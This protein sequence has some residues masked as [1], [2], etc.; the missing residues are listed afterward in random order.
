[1]HSQKTI[2]S[3]LNEKTGDTYSLY[4]L[5]ERDYLVVETNGQI[6]NHHIYSTSDSYSKSLK[7]SNWVIEKINKEQMCSLKKL[8]KTHD[9]IVLNITFIKS[10]IVFVE[11]L[12]DFKKFEIEY[13]YEFHE[14]TIVGGKKASSVP[15]NYLIQ[16]AEKAIKN[17]TRYYYC[18]R[19]DEKFVNWNFYGS[20]YEE[21]ALCPNK[22]G[23]HELLDISDRM[24]NACS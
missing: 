20:G 1:M 9:P 13:D 12:Y 5:D 10:G 3:V 18:K 19:C 23:N 8:I 17:K 24:L 21:I 6:T 2:L 7:S 15:L 16:L 22:C 14:Y 4:L 11:V